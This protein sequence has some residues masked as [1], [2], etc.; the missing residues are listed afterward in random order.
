[1]GRLFVPGLIDDA[2][3]ASADDLNEVGVALGENS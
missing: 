3:G 2:I 1:M